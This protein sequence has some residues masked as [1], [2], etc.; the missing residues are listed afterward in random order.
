[1]LAAD[2][3]LGRIA[4]RVKW[5]EP[6]DVTLSDLDDFLCR[7]MALG[8]WEDMVY[9]EQTFGEEAFVHA[10]AQCPPGVMDPA[11][12]HYWHH[13]LGKDTVPPLPQRSFA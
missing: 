8:L 7:V 3:T 10:L 12:W 4:R 6:E 5:W 1:M 13:R 2:P 9:A 11:S